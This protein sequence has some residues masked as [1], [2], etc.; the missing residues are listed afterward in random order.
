MNRTTIGLTMSTALLAACAS[1]APAPTAAPVMAAVST[2][3]PVVEEEVVPEIDE[4]AE[5]AWQA[6]LSTRGEYLDSLA[7]P[8][9]ACAEQSEEKTEAVFQTCTPQDWPSMVQ[10]AYALQKLSGLTADPRYAN[11]AQDTLSPEVI[12]TVTKSLDH[13]GVGGSPYAYTWLLGVASTVDSP[14]PELTALAQRVA[15][16]LE[17]WLT[18]LPGYD[19]LRGVM[20]GAPDSVAWVAQNLWQYADATGD[21]E[22]ASRMRAY[23]K[24]ELA[25]EDYDEWC[26]LTVDEQPEEYELFPPCLHRV[27]AVLTVM[28]EDQTSTWLEGFLPEVVSIE[29]LDRASWSTHAALNFSRSWGLWALYNATGDTQWRDLYVDHVTTQMDPAQ[30]SA[31]DEVDRPWIA[32][33]GVLAIGLSYGAASMPADAFAGGTAA[34]PQ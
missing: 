15:T 26:S 9:V 32:H 11:L 7:A 16:E 21:A 25:T 30:W 23:T 4:Q 14:S 27:L 12:A 17:I 2:P 8:L 22:L 18:E 13:D 1:T 29:P 19:M 24:T 3:A 34:A 28:P 10:S 33:F 20:I 6:F 31:I 5:Q